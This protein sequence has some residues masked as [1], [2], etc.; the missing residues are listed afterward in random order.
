MSTRYLHY[1]FQPNSV[2]VFG[3]SERQMS[4]GGIV[5][6]NLLASGFEG[7]L[8]AVNL[9]PYHS[10]YGVRCYRHLKTLPKRPELAI[11]CTPPHTIPHLVKELGIYGIKAVL[12]LTGGMS[13]AQ[14]KSNKIFEEFQNFFNDLLGFELSKK[15]PRLLKNLIQEVANRYDM[16]LMGPNCIGVLVAES[17]LNASYAH[18]DIH[19][20][21]IAFIG[22]SG[23]LSMAMLDWANG[24]DIGFSHFTSLGDSMDVE[25]SD[26][27][28]Y[29]V[30]D[31][32]TKVILL[33]I[34]TLSHARR[35]ISSVRAAARKKLVV[36]LKSGRFS[37][38][39]ETPEPVP[40]G[41]RHGDCVYRAMLR[42]AGVLRLE[43]TD[44]LLDT[45]S[46][47]T[48]MKPLNGQR[49]AIMSNGMGP[50]LLAVDALLRQGGELARLSDATLTAL[51][52]ILPAFWSRQHP[53]D[54]NADAQAERY[55]TTLRLMAQD[56]NVDAVLIIY[57]PSVQSDALIVAERIIQTSQEL[58]CNVL[59]CWMGMGKV[60]S[61]RQA[62]DK[63]KIP[64]FVTPEEAIDAFMQ[65]VKHH[66][67]QASALQ[68]PPLFLNENVRNR[69]QAWYWINHALD[70][71]RD[72]LTTEE[73]KEVLAAYHIFLKSSIESEQISTL[74]T[75]I[76]EWTPPYRLQLLHTALFKP[77]Y[78]ANDVPNQDLTLE[79]LHKGE[80][81]NAANQLRNELNRHFPQSQFLG[82]RLQRM[83]RD[84]SMMRLRV[85]VTRH[86][87]GGPVIF[88]DTG[89]NA[90]LN[91][92]TQEVE[93]LPINLKLARDLIEH[94]KINQWLELYTLEPDKQIQKL[95]EILVQLSQIVVDVPIIKTLELILL[96]HREGLVA[97]QVAIALGENAELAIQPYPEELQSETVLSTGET[98]LLRPI[99]GEDEPAHLHFLEQLSPRAIRY[100]FFNH[101]YKISHSELARLTQI[102]YAREMAFI[103]V[104]Q[105]GNNA[106]TIGAV[107]A[108]T[109]ADNIQAEFAIVISDKY[110]RCG[111][112]TALI[113]KLIDYCQ[114]RG[115]LQM[116]G[117]V[118]PDNEAMLKL[119][120]KLGFN[121]FYDKTEEI[122]KVSL[123][124]NPA[125][126]EW[127]RT[128]LWL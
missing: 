1:F 9:K 109:D 124:L 11:L 125:N 43:S 18:S 97:H 111:L 25:F 16:R 37:A 21:A 92:L 78:I 12:V 2:A 65:M 100:R 82:Y 95:S 88:I 122:M 117:T 4:M 118:L 102:D 85:G 23:I 48:R 15:P 116:I 64:S 29:L 119:V 52:P 93:L 80:L 76:S 120:K 50:N 28:D 115:T 83:Q 127:Q 36:V 44:E 71:Q 70:H 106:V 91:I 33:H 24:R 13:R 112:G 60:E 42:R 128:R 45:L 57:G 79:I 30:E 62:F 121:V 26:L 6:K 14:S 35:F 19:K 103:A 20:G 32:N 5:I 49:L 98:L 105:Q 17:R 86:I 87:V 61:A 58:P 7:Q 59:T 89:L 39:Q 8:M 55:A 47:L 22:Q 90:L 69:Q 114:K 56:A 31:E 108:Y 3:A 107:R 38:S 72:W 104:S 99:R 81:E 34:E 75:Q 46:V 68:T 40:L 41:L 113:R 123:H 66:R 67:N 54:L 96:S 84:G 63:A 73:A 101:K 27:I 10:V 126:F 53:I 94:N 77:F 74:I 51:V 110:S